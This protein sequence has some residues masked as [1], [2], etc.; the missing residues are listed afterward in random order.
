MSCSD[1]D[2]C[3]SQTHNC[4]PGFGCKNTDGGFTCEDIDECS[5]KNQCDINSS[6]VNTKGSYSCTCKK[7]FTGDGRSCA[8][9]N[10][11]NSNPCGSNEACQNSVGSYKC[12]ACG[13]GMKPNGSECIDINECST[14]T[15]RCSRVSDAY[16]NLKFVES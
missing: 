6:C 9:I 3:S 13:T 14:G 5:I 2:E 8:D 16:I 15:H 7:G 12:K 10:E 4:Q 11:C 1:I